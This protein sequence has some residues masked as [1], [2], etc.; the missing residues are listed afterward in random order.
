MLWASRTVCL[1]VL[2]L[3]PCLVW[4]QLGIVEPSPDNS[5]VNNNCE[6]NPACEGEVSPGDCRGRV[7]PRPDCPCCRVCARQEWVPCSNSTQP[8]DS[9]FG[10]VCSPEGVCKGE[11]LIF[12]LKNNMTTPI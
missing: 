10:L 3:L 4:A 2:V 5:T 12:I 7:V 11:K 6:C 1:L 9:E 8:C